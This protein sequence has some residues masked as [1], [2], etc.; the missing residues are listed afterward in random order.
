MDRVLMR[1]LIAAAVTGLSLVLAGCG[2]SVGPTS[3]T[4]SAATPTEPTGRVTFWDISA[5]GQPDPVYE[6]LI[7]KFAADNPQVKVEAAW[8]AADTALEQIRSAANSNSAADVLRID[9]DWT[10]RL[11]A[12]GS[13][14][15]LDDTPLTA[16]PRD[17]LPV[18]YASSVFADQQWAVPQDVDVTALLCNQRLFDE[19][20]LTVPDTWAQIARDS[21]TMARTGANIIAAPVDTWGLLP[22]L[23]SEGGGLINTG[24]RTIDI[25][26]PGSVAGFQTALDLINNGVAVP[27]PERDA[28]TDTQERFAEGRL[29]CAV[30]GVE[31]A[32]AALSSDEFGAASDLQVAPPPDGSRGGEANI[33]GHNL[34]VFAGSEN[35]AAAYELVQFLN[36]AERQEQIASASGRLPTRPDVYSDIDTSTRNGQ[37]VSDFKPALDSARPRPSLPQLGEMM[38]SL[39]TQWRRMYTD[40]TTAAEGADQIALEWAQILPRDYTP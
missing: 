21:P 39:D 24:Q 1:P 3:P 7:A 23:Y 5:D 27:P 25:N 16:E 17:F 36:S 11:A 37:L 34:A 30:D 38:R 28:L 15:P 35:R 33:S 8:I 4:P 14:Q 31:T 20:G 40:Q 32:Q 9:A 12:E 6:L 29:A 2:S 26:D 18:A 19:A 22:Y 13:L 10:A